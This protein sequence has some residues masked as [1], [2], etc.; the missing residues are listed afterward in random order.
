MG[1]RIALKTNMAKRYEWK[2][3]LSL[4]ECR[5]YD[6]YLKQLRE[7]YPHEHWR[8]SHNKKYHEACKNGFMQMNCTID[9]FVKVVPNNNLAK[10]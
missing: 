9:E 10:T 3:S 1:V 5:Q 2:M 4:E 7:D 6:K 8:V